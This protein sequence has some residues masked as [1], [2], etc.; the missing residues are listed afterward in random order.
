ML[1]VTISC[2]HHPCISKTV[3][4]VID[5]YVFFFHLT[6]ARIK[7]KSPKIM[8]MKSAHEKESI[9][10]DGSSFS[11]RNLFALPSDDL[12][13]VHFTEDSSDHDLLLEV[14]SSGSFPQAELL[15]S[16][17]R[18]QQASASSSSVHQHLVHQ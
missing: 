12:D 8:I 2:N 10:G 7:I 16:A 14:P 18:S 13:S 3:K 4:T 11:P 1:S 6:E 17:T 15:H 9:D 5:I